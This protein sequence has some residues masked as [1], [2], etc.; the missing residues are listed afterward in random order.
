M[1]AL[2]DEYARGAGARDSLD[3]FFGVGR[4]DRLTRIPSRRAGS[5]GRT[6]FLCLYL[7]ADARLPEQ[8]LSVRSPL[9]T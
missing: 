3:L 8:S 9:V 7:P 4:P 2:R 1:S 5:S 6:A